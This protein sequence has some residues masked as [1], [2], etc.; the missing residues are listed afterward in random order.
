[1]PVDI[2]DL[3]VTR[4]ELGARA[5]GLRARMAAAGLDALLLTTGDN[6]KYASGYPSP[7]RS[8]PR[9]FLFLLPLSGEPVFFCHA[10]REGEARRFCWCDDIRTYYPLSHAPVDLLAQAFQEHHL[11]AGQVGIEIGAEQCFDIPLSDFLRLQ[12][13]LPTVRF[14]DAAPVLWGARLHKTAR[15]IA[16]IRLACTITSSAYE[17]AFEN[18]RAGMSEQEAAGLVKDAMLAQ[19]AEDTWLLMTSGSGNYDLVSRGPS[20]RRLALGDFLYIDC[21][22]AVAGYWCDFDRVGVVGAPTPEQR[23]AQHFAEEVTAAAI[24]LVRPGASTREIALHCAAAL[25]RFPYPIS[26]DI[27]YLAARIGHGIGISA[28]EP[29]N[30]AVYEDTLLEPGM[31][32]TVEPGVA[33][34]FGVFH[35][36]QN[37]LVTETGCEVLSTAP[38]ILHS[39]DG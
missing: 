12:K 26:S 28:L 29:P 8:G 39:I 19:G 20:R 14:I 30:I 31:V 17:T 37:V 16:R 7:L 4:D 27:G 24:E 15:E 25:E 10:G 1:L 11:A 35:V 9:P 2:P 21:G 34:S 13:A 6:L 3:S 36:E 18:F 32:I 23:D 22:C 5:A 38:T 33:T